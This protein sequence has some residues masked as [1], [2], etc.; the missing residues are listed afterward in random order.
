MNPIV[1]PIW[2][3]LCSVI[4]GV[5][6]IFTNFWGVYAI[7]TAAIIIFGALFADD[8]IVKVASVVEFVKKWLKIGI[9]IVIISLVADAFIPSQDTCYQMLVASMVT[10]DNIE[11]VGN[12]ATDLIDYIVDK[13]DTMLDEEGAK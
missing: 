10:E 3:Y 4:D 9:P 5:K 2:F 11:Y 6:S 1:N 7:C 8:G 12:K 13:V